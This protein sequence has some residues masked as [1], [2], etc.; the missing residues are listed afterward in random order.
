MQFNYQN[1]MYH[2]QKASHTRR[3]LVSLYSFMTS[4]MLSV[5]PVWWIKRSV[6]SEPVLRKI[7]NT[8]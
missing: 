1:I 3:P 5:S 4:S 2:G 6:S 7:Y 8:K